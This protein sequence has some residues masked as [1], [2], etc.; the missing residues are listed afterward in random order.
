MS[1]NK[2]ASLG[3]RISYS[4]DN[5]MARG[6][7]SIFL[8]LL[9]LF[10]VAFLIM[11]GIRVVLA[12]IFPDTTLPE[13]TDNFW[14]TFIEIADAGNIGSDSDS[15]MIHKAAGVFSIVCGM[16]L[17]SGLVAFISNQF[18]EKIEDLRKGKS[19]VIETNHTLILGFRDRI[20]EIIREL[21]IANES[22]KDAAV[23]ILAEEGK[24]VMD[25]FFNEHLTDRKSTRI[26]TRSGT[27]SSIESLKKMGV[28]SA[29]TIVILN[30]VSSSATL[31]HKSAADARVLKTI[32]AVVAASQQ[33]EKFPPI[34]AEL[35]IARNRKLAESVVPGSI[36]TMDEDGILSRLLVQTSRT[37]G[38][39]IVYSNLV[40][41][42]GNEVY[43][44][45]PKSGWGN[46]TFGEIQFRF[47][48]SVPLGFRQQ[49]G[50]ILLNP[51]KDFRPG[52]SD[53]AIMLA[54]DDSAIKFSG[55]AVA[56]VREYP[57]TNKK[58]QSGIER[59]LISGWNNK[60]P[61][62]IAEYA[63]YIS[64]GSEIDII[65]P[66]PDENLMARFRE[67]QKK[68]EKHKMRMLKADIHSP[69]VL[70][71]LMPHKY[72][73]VILLAAEGE[74]AEEIDAE[75]ISVLMQLRQNFRAVEKSGQT[76]LTKII[77]EVM[78]SDNIELVLQ[79]GVKDFLISNQFVSKIFAQ[80]SQEPNVM[81]V[82]DDLFSPEGSEIYLKKVSVYF[83]DSPMQVTFA[84]CAHAAQKRNEVC[85]GLRIIAQE[86][87]PDSNY[88]VHLIPTKTQNFTLNA[89]DELIVLAEDES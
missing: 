20:I 11:S 82:Y 34:V 76:V 21:V 88:G 4:I 57:V 24:E 35:H 23:V 42:E 83:P 32:M 19:R 65:V 10:V 12:L 7:L 70:E 18:E 8:A 56:A 46:L 5:F 52:D 77:T 22:E 40:G 28:E 85:F 30:G 48:E 26:I 9:V 62:I 44:Y 75:T 61:V 71:K 81:K 39:S 6:G 53:D 72:D 31:A 50:K 59:H 89:D 64:E 84:D 86:R 78:D 45:R 51:Q 74:N 13:I 43:F 47:N 27:T 3:N 2:K 16:V 1:D 15:N 69:E 60:S 87:E 54:E 80:V 68:H 17:F 38:L 63:K 79:T 49:D 14:R 36:T 29:K 37:S 25:D 73:N 55:A 66:D 67:I 41:F 58:V 33:T